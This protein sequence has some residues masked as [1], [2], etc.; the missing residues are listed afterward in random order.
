MKKKII[1]ITLSAVM[2]AGTIGI[3]GCGG[4][5]GNSGGDATTTASGSSDA[6]TT[7]S[8]GS[9]S[10]K[11]SGEVTAFVGTSIF[12]SSLD[13]I[14]GSM[15]YGYPFICNALLKVDSK[16]EYVADLADSWEIAADG[17]TYTFKLKKDIKF[18]DGSDF[19]AEDVVFTYK[20]V[21]ENQANNENVDLT[22]LKDVKAVDDYTVEFTLNEAYSPFFDTVAMQQIVPSDAYDSDA[23]DTKPIGTGAFKVADYTTNQQ[24]I[25]ET[26]KDCFSG[27]PAIDKITLV[28]M[29]QD[30]AIAAAKSGQLDIVMVSPQYAKE[31]IDGMTIANLKTMDVRQISLPVLEEQEMK[32]AEGNTRKVGNNIT[33][34][35][36]VRKALAIG[37]DRQTVI[38]NG[39]NG[40]GKPAKSFVNLTWSLDEDYQDG[41]VDEAKKVL[42]AAGWKDSD[43]DGIVEK[44][45][46]ACEF[47]VIAPGNDMDRYNLAMALAEDA[48]NIGIK[49]NVK[50]LSWDEAG[51]LTNCTPIVWGWGQYN[52]IVIDSLLGSEKFL[53]GAY[54]NVVGY[55]NGNTDAGIQAALKATSNEDAVKNW[56][57]AQKAAV[58]DYPYLYLVNIE[59]SYFINNNLDI[60]ESTQIMHPHGHGSPIVCNIADW[61]WK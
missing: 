6:T 51:E 34:D 52:P 14:K 30:A 18:S 35:P 17:L 43:G 12:G 55:K 44:D 15:A 53:A 37:V 42:E 8:G 46:K 26:N 3:A 61:S 25:L 57:D 39:L 7:A 47:D 50:N 23:F 33:A 48:K 9:G 5:G 10:G 4:G 49:I 45:G 40:I 60:S 59:H 36:A 1:P 38:D 16:S 54:D 11:S 56:K 21:K 29:D 32:D 27:A 19:N 58:E 28:Y 24:I 2:L 22:C 13:P 31:S 41:Q 20:T